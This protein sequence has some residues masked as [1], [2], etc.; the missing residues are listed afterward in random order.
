MLKLVIS[1]LKL[2]SAYDAYE[3]LN[4]LDCP[5]NGRIDAIQ[6][7]CYTCIGSIRSMYETEAMLK[8]CC[9]SVGSVTR[10]TEVGFGQGCSEQTCDQ[11]GVENSMVNI[12][13]LYS[14][15]ESYNFLK[16]S[17]LPIN[18]KCDGKKHC[19][20]A[21][22]ELGCG[23]QDD[24]LSCGDSCV[25]F[26]LVCD[27]EKNC[28][29]GLDEIGCPMM[30]GHCSDEEFTCGR[31]AYAAQKCISKSKICDGNKDCPDGMDEVNCDQTRA[32]AGEF[33]CRNG[34]T[35]RIDDVCVPERA[36]SDGSSMEGCYEWRLWG[37]WQNLCDTNLCTFY[38]RRQCVN[39]NNGRVDSSMQRCQSGDTVGM[40]Q[41]PE[42]GSPT[43][44][45][46]EDYSVEISKKNSPSLFFFF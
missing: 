2:T 27:G 17:H 1:I 29:S 32:S 31:R 22:D 39:I 44:R 12:K 37:E 4:M 25:N 9:S 19:R 24:Q 42:F 34:Q 7:T 3:E 10:F 43:T 15:F 8:T 35:I 6:N 36:C 21:E 18:L 23:C 28:R 33:R 38:R 46:A 5:G 26:S 16:F 30:T 13:N 11:V 20:G 41:V 14:N 45:Y 40:N